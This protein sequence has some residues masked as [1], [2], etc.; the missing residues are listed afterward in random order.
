MKE[1]TT[2]KKA[3]FVQLVRQFGKKDAEHFI[4]SPERYD[5]HFDHDTLKAYLPIV[6]EVSK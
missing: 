4:L 5:H 6:E 1:L 3:L 2:I